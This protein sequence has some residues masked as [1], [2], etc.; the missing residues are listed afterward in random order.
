MRLHKIR[1]EKITLFHLKK[2]ISFRSVFLVILLFSL[3][4]LS[5]DFGF[6]RLFWRYVCNYSFK[7]RFSVVLC[8]RKH[9][10]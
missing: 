1:V 5:R 4:H 3:K 8:S 9:A 7:S 2:F 6:K 10:I